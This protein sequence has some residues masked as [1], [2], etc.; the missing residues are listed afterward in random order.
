MNISQGLKK[1]NKLA[2]EAQDAFNKVNQYNSVRTGST[3]PY[4][5]G[6]LF[7]KYSKKT[8]ELVALK[9]QI[10]V[11]S[12]PV[13]AKI[14]EL[15]ELKSMAS[16]VTRLNVNQGIITD[17]YRMNSTEVEYEVI[18]DVIWKDNQIKEYETKIEA[19]QDELDLFNHATQLV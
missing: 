4:V 9:T 19:I 16:Q 5:I 6:E 11:A 12:E 13:R 15:S 10:H 2:K 7:E 17:G 8:A 14:F 18:L 1:K 3:R